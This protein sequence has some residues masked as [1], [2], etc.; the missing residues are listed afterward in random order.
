MKLSSASIDCLPASV[1]DLVEV[2]GLAAAL[3]IV[4]ERG[5]I[6]LCVPTRVRHDHWLMDGIG[7]QAFNNLVDM[8][9]GEEIE[10]PRC[11]AAMRALREQE[12][13]NAGES[14][15]QLARRYG[16][17][18]RGIRKLKRRVGDKAPD[19]QQELF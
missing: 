1:Q 18:E 7:A 4:E 5:G 11:H 19:D 3:V 12:I 15:S 8:Y 10:I 13:V 2:I 17:T 9:A 16:Y 6:R 14:N